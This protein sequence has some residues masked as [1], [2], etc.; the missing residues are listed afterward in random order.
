MGCSMSMRADAEVGRS[1]GQGGRGKVGTVLAHQ[2]GRRL[3]GHSPSHFC[4]RQA[5]SSAPIVR[6]Y[7][8]AMECLADRRSGFHNR[9]ANMKQATKLHSCI[10][11]YH[12][13]IIDL[14]SIALHNP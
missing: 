5:T 2:N 11:N 8:K 10:A 3:I 6:L 9:V 7:P 12:I 14:P 13:K 1:A 4:F